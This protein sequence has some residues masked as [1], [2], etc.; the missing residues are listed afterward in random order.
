D[1]TAPNVEFGYLPSTDMNRPVVLVNAGVLSRTPSTATMSR[2]TDLSINVA[3]D[4]SATFIYRLESA[5]WAAE[6]GR[7]LLRMQ[8]PAQREESLQAELRFVNL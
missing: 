1:S 3:H 6:Q 7:T 5:G 2:T 8:T 4:G